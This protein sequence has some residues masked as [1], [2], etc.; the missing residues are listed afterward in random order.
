MQYP[1]RPEEGVRNPGTRV[2]DGCEPSDGVLGME[3]RFSEGAAG[4]LNC[5]AI[6]LATHHLPCIDLLKIH[7]LRHLACTEFYTDD[8]A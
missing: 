8:P 5:R 4:I 1:R 2:V 6:F 7:P 3:L